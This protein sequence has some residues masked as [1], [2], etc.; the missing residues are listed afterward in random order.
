MEDAPDQRSDTGDVPDRRVDEQRI[1]WLDAFQR[2]HPVI[3]FPL[4][5]FYKYFDDSG[6][7]LA[8]LITY[9]GFLSLFPL[10]LILSTI[11]GAVLK[12]EGH[13]R[14]QILESAL[15][16]FPLVG[17]QLG[18]PAQL[19]GGGIGLAIGIVGSLYGGL[20]VAQALQYA[21]N[22]AWSVPRNS[23]PN[24]FKARG[25]S[26]QLLLIAG[27]AVLATTTV[28]IV[29]NNGSFGGGTAQLIASVLGGVVSTGILVIVFRRA[30]ARPLTV[31]QVLPG[32]ISAAIAWQLLQRF[33]IVY[34]SR[35]VQHAST[36]N[37]VFA[38]VLG[39]IAF[40]YVAAIALVFSIEINVVRVNRL[41]PR[42]LLTPFTDNVVLTEGDKRSYI[43]IAEAQRHKG[44][45]QIEVQFDRRQ[46][47]EPER[48]SAEIEPGELE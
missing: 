6:A 30:T 14:D 31:L 12:Q 17:D 24:P 8:A 39:L 3:G 9:Y 36:T 25:R 44:F 34:V 41:Y 20:G 48:S 19:G 23:R 38:L 10:L 33:G 32:A 46:V 18:D 28:S 1:P 40:I 15:A 47:R 29:A 7:Y 27:L 2:R 43:G 16:Q 11:L 4:A 22:T 35:V 26:L 21:M 5:V 42:S 13:L 37:S 45:E